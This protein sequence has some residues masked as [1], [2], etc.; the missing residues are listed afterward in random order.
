[1]EGAFFEANSFI[2]SLWPAA[3]EGRRRGAEGERAGRQREFVK[4]D[5]EGDLPRP[6]PPAPPPPPPLRPPA[7]ARQ[8]DAGTPNG[9]ASVI[10]SATEVGRGR[11]GESEREG[12]PK[13]SRAAKVMIEKRLAKEKVRTSTGSSDILW[14]DHRVRV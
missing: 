1:M 10:S 7:P 3:T 6:R 5:E 2:H 9:G 13:F 12:E 8:S 14:F 11:E 4:L